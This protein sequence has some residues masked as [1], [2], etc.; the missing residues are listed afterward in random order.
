MELVCVFVR[1]ENIFE[2]CHVWFFTVYFMMTIYEYVNSITHMDSRFDTIYWFI[3]RRRWQ[4]EAMLCRMSSYTWLVLLF[5]VHTVTSVVYVNRCQSLKTKQNKSQQW[6][7]RHIAHAKS[8]KHVHSTTRETNQTKLKIQSIED[9]NEEC[10]NSRTSS[11]DVWT[12]TVLLF[13]MHI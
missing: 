6:I 2:C 3:W 9:G 5:M 12:R 11:T 13:E 8:I 4:Q 1:W 7:H 10:N